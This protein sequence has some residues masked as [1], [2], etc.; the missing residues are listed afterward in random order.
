[1]SD[2]NLGHMIARFVRYQPKGKMLQDIAR[3]QTYEINKL[4]SNLQ[5]STSSTTS[6]TPTT[7]QGSMPAS[8]FSG[9][10]KSVYVKDLMKLPRNMNEL[11]VKI[12][13]NLSQAE[14]NKLLSQHAAARR[15]PL[16]QT[17]A[18]ILAQLQGLN[19]AEM[20]A[21]MKA[22]LASGQTSSA[23]KNLQISA[24]QMI[25]LSDIS[26]LIQSNGKEAVTKLILAMAN[27]AKQGNGDIHQLKETA[28]LINASIAMASSDNP[29]QTLKTLM[30]L[31]L[32]WLPLHEGA[33][34]DI[35]V[36]VGGSGSPSDSILI[37]T[38]TTV[39]YGI[40]T[41]T[42]LLE[43]QNAVHINIECSEKFPKD[44]LLKRMTEDEKHYSMQSIISVDTKKVSDNIQKP[45]STNAKINMSHTNE[46][47][48]YLLLAA[49]SLIR[50][51]IELDRG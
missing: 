31:Y 18:Q 23:I 50:Y 10:D 12:Q 5:S 2:F 8:S 3:P 36:E 7:P 19:T 35:D 39:N 6:S 11:M 24:S 38:I 40:L 13:Q 25:N 14:L 22:Q 16:S 51:V 43:N 9:A 4:N 42:L 49:H 26:V 27:A 30:L 46:I 15:N 33:D 21:V 17:Q 45:E 32:P 29:A 28:K 44:E 34:F 41:A 20:Q 1:M 47:S 37:V 48:P